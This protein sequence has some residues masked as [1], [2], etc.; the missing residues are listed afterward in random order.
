MLPDLRAAA[1]Q[2]IELDDAVHIEKGILQK[3]PEQMC[4]HVLLMMRRVCLVMTQFSLS[5]PT[6]GARDMK[7]F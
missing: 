4:S 1:R 6:N 5:V 2:R 3:S 7:D